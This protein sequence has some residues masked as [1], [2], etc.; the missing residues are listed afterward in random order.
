M[1]V[2]GGAKYYCFHQNSCNGL[3]YR[4]RLRLLVL[5]EVG[6]VA[7]KVNFGTQPLVLAVCN[8]EPEYKA[9]QNRVPE[10]RVMA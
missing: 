3:A 2:Y 6:V 9:S 4:P 1:S 8:Q 10:S 7:G 5:S